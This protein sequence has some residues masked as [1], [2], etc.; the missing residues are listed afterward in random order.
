M[1]NAALIRRF[2]RMF[3]CDSARICCYPGRMFLIIGNN[4]STRQNMKET[5]S[6]WH[7]DGKPFHFK[8]LSEM[9]IAS[10]STEA[11]LIESAKEYKRLSRLTPQEFFRE[12]TNEPK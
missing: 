10:G 1:N 4:R 11:E 6:C 8:Y 9:V 3:R 12:L 5:G 7:K 2:I